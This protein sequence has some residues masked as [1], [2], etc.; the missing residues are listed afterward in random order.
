[1]DLKL[2]RGAC[3]LG[4]AF[5]LYWAGDALAC[6]DGQSANSFGSCIPN[7]GGTIGQAGEHI[8]RELQGQF[9]AP[10]L[11]AWINGSYSTAMNGS[12][13]VP[14][15]IRAMLRGYIPEPVMDATRYKIGDNGFLNAAF[16]TQHYGDSF[17]GDVR[18]TTLVTVIVFNSQAD[19]DDPALWAHE[20]THVQQYRNWG[21]HDFAV[22]YARNFN[23]VEDPA[24]QVGDG[25]WPW[26]Q[27]HPTAPPPGPVMTPPPPAPPSQR[28][29]IPLGA[30]FRPPR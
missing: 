4:S 3:A 7:A 19:V 12:M 15:Y 20:L 30:G 2:R 23:E 25:F 10:V 14:I 1:M 11:E 9:V 6:P 27:A 22:H 21:A 26:R 28:A 16:A 24:Y 8:R 13:P 29:P 17:G 18:A 5:A